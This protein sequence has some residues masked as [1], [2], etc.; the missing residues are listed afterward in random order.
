MKLKKIFALA[1]MICLGGALASCQA[2]GAAASPTASGNSPASTALSNTLTDSPDLDLMQAK[3]PEEGDTKVILHTNFGDITIRFFPEETPLAYENFVTHAREGYYDGVIFH[4]VI[5]NFMIQGGDP[6]G[7][8]TG[9]ESIWGHGFEVEFSMDLRH[10]RGALAMAHAGPG[11]LGSQFYIVHNS[12]IDPG[13]RQEFAQALEHQDD[14]VGEDLDGNEIYLRDLVS[15][16]KVEAYGT[17]GGTPHLDL[18]MNPSGHTVFGQVV[19]GMDVVD[20]IATTEVGEH[21]RPVEDVIIESVTVST[22]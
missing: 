3:P 1:G 13:M 10:F 22:F 12:S 20:A 8:G 14:F 17:Y 19:E 15:P 21:D 2:T 16:D 4:R 11:T 7:T 5:E 6:L 18:V 9:G